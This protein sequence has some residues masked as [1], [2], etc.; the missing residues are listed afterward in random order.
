MERSLVRGAEG[1]VQPGS[2][3]DGEGLFFLGRDEQL[4]PAALPGEVLEEGKTLR[5]GLL[6]NK[7]QVAMTVR[8][9]GAAREP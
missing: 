4:L 3:G 2:L 1:E 9:I 7:G 5:V 8:I 6:N